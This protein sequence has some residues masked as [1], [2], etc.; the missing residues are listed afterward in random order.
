M[1]SWM[2]YK[3][4]DP[5]SFVS[6]KLMKK[7][8]ILLVLFTLALMAAVVGVVLNTSDEP[9]HQGRELSEWLRDLLDTPDDPRVLA[10]VQAIGTNAVP[11]L[12]LGFSYSYSSG[13][14][15][16]FNAANRWARRFRLT[17]PIRDPAQ[18]RYNGALAGFKALGSTGSNAIP[19]LSKLLGGTNGSGAARA[20]SYIGPSALPALVEAVGNS[21]PGVRYH[22]LI[23]VA[24]L[25]LNADLALPAVVGCLYDTNMA[26]GACI[27]YTAILALTEMRHKARSAEPDLKQLLSDPD[28]TMQALAQQALDKMRVQKP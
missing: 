20:M 14:E 3:R 11:H 13:R 22:G 17:E 16:F 21:S 6:C 18:A 1:L 10:A 8:A 9:R 27:R 15:Q 26:Y 19:Y 24:G 7:R 12:L 25:G 2:P 23:G 5:F 28:L 4:N